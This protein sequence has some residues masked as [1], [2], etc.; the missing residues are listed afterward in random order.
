MVALR[1]EALRQMDNLGALQHA[2]NS[3]TGHGDNGGFTRMT[4]GR[5]MNEID[6]SVFEWPL[7]RY[8]PAEPE[9]YRSQE[10]QEYQIPAK[11]NEQVPSSYIDLGDLEDALAQAAC[12]Y[13]VDLIYDAT[14]DLVKESESDA[15][16]AELVS[17][18]NDTNVRQD[19]GTPDLVVCA[20]GKGDRGVE[21]Q[22]NFTR[23]IGVFLTDDSLPQQNGLESSNALNLDGKPDAEIESQLFSV[24]GLKLADGSTSNTSKGNILHQIR[25]YKTNDVTQPVVDIEMNHASA[26]HCLLQIPRQEPPLPTNAVQ[27]EEYMVERVNERLGTTYTS[28]KSMREQD[29]IVWGDPLRPVVVETATAPQYVFGTNVVLIGDAAMSCSPSSGMGAEVGL[30]V[31]SQSI[32]ELAAGL[33]HVKTLEDKQDLLKLFNTRKAE[34]AIMWSQGSRTYYLEKREADQILE[35]LRSASQ[36]IDTEPGS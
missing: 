2:L 4:Q 24:F 7:K 28:V 27:F 32:G 8:P 26:A 9:E 17:N 33:K 18:T 16:R 21:K 13:G 19:L 34:S 6:G 30:T 22:L 5:T 36:A 29:L 15:Y 25:K 35:S 14:I 1:P 11:V 12:D 3:K 23:R 20:S 31:D 10:L